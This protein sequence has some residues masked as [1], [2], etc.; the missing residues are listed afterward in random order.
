MG[1]RYG[2]VRLSS[3]LVS[4]ATVLGMRGRV[5]LGSDVITY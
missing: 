4:E 3:K 5:E 1:F 2:G